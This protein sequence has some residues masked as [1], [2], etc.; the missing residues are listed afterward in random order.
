MREQIVDFF[1]GF[2]EQKSETGMA[3]KSTAADITTEQ[4]V[5]QYTKSNQNPKTNALPEIIDSISISDSDDYM[6]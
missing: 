2:I 1:I 3:T 6:P 4:R 5:A